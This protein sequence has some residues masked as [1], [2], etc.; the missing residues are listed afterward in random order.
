MGS[1]IG[2]AEFDSQ[3]ELGIFLSTTAFRPA[4]EPT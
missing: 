2:V 4:L 1:M 3:Q